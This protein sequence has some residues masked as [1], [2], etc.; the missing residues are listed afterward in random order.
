MDEMKGEINGSRET[1]REG[2]MT[3]GNSHFQSA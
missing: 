2:R 1:R 3:S